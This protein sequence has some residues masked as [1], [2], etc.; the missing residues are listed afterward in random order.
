[1]S[2]RMIRRLA[3][4]VCPGGAALTPVAKLALLLCLGELADLISGHIDLDCIAVTSKFA[5][6]YGNG[7]ATVPKEAA[8]FQNDSGDLTIWSG[9]HAAKRAKL[10]SVRT[11]SLWCIAHPPDPTAISLPTVNSQLNFATRR[12]SRR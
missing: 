4:A 1:M 9:F 3:S 8:Y 2:C 10:A 6:G 11:A 12:Q 7:L 5:F